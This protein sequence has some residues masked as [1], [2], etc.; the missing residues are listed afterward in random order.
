MHRLTTLTSRPH[1]TTSQG[2]LETS[3]PDVIEVTIVLQ[4][5][6]VRPFLASAPA[7]Q[8]LFD[9][10]SLMVFLLNV[11]LYSQ[12]PTR[13]NISHKLLNSRLALMA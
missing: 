12:R 7:I 10:N 1:G 11:V 9:N 8:Q 13:F 2:E 3:C 4:S 5:A 6:E